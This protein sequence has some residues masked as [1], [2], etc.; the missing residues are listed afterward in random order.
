MNILRHRNLTKAEEKRMSELID[1]AVREEVLRVENEFR[2][3]IDAMILYTLHAHYGWGKKRLR[4]FWDAFMEEHKALREF[5]QMSGPGEN[6]YLAKR[7][8]KQIGVD[9]DAWEAE[10]D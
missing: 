6:A 1:Q 2:S 10:D 4:R 3:D 5:Y 8:L 9:L 7:K